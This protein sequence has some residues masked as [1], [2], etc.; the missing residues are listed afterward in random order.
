MSQRTKIQSFLEP[1]ASAAR[2]LSEATEIFDTDFE[3]DGSEFEDE[4]SP[5]GSFETV[6]SSPSP[7]IRQHVILTII[8]G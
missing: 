5:K 2:P 8:S 3:D 6:F 1:R 4:Y 7:L